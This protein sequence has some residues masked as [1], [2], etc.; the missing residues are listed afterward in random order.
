MLPTIRRRPLFALFVGFAPI[1]LGGLLNAC[2]TPRGAPEFRADH[3]HSPTQ[4]HA[5]GRRRALA[6]SPDRA[7][8]R[9]LR[10]FYTADYRK[11]DHW[12]GVPLNVG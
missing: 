9:F 3:R 12:L 10:A 4:V 7:A 6:G 8:V 5:H 2:R 1:T 11:R